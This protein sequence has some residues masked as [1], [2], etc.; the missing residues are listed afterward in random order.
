MVRKTFSIV[1]EDVLRYLD[2]MEKG[3]MSRYV[4]RLIK[5]DMKR[6]KGITRDEVIRLIQEYGGKVEVTKKDSKVI[7]AAR[8][9]ISL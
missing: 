7:N 1:D 8:N 9:L 3:E 5:E 6:D 4:S 2:S